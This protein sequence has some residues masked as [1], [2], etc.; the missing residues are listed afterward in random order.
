MT[1]D[2]EAVFEAA[3]IDLLTD[4]YG[5]SPEVLRYPTEETLIQNWA[6]ILYENNRDVDRLNDVPLTDSEMQQILEQITRLRT[7]LNLNGFINGKTVAIKRDN[8]ADTLHYGKEVSLKIY[9]RKEIAAG[10]SRYQIA[11][12][13]VFKARSSVLPDR[14]GDFM[15]LINGMPVIHVELKRSGVDVSQA[16]HQ[17]EKYAHEGVFSGLFSLVQIFIAMEP[18]N[19][20][21]FA[22]PGPDGK[23]NPDY[24]F[25]WADFNNEEVHDWTLKSPDRVY[26]LAVQDHPEVSAFIRIKAGH[27]KAGR[28]EYKRAMPFFT[29]RF[30][31]FKSALGTLLGTDDMLDATKN[32]R[33]VMDGGPEF[34]AQFGGFLL[35]VGSYV[36]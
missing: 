28:G 19:A 3:M 26:A 15:L 6:Q 13:P 33:I 34:G 9:D 11:E 7:P 27:S 2:N 29:L 31:S 24:Y 16:Y 22:N 25:H 35:T 10:Q 20:V 1:F 5:W 14:R 8:P 32:G 36:Q 23:F 12:Q 30:D 4:K 21:Y 18:E 17:I